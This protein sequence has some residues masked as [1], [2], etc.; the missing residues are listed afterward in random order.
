MS[1]LTYITVSSY[2]KFSL[3]QMKFFRYSSHIPKTCV[4]RESHGHRMLSLLTWLE[5][6]DNFT[7]GSKAWSYYYLGLLILPHKTFLFI[8]W[9]LTNQWPI[10]A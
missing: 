9:S 7:H 5:L 10:L 2:L 6:E 3:N 1:V 4:V 8:Q